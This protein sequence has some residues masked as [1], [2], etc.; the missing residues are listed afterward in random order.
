MAVAFLVDLAAATAFDFDFGAGVFP[1]SGL[2]AVLGALPID[3]AVALGAMLALAAGFPAA[4]A[5]VFSVVVGLVALAV[6]TDLVGLAF[7][8]P[9]GLS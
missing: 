9:F 5:V 7:S 2:L 1:F 6:A 8:L 3:L 4:L